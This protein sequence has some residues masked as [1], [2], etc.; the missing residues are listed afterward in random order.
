MATLVATSVMVCTPAL[1]SSM[2]VIGLSWSDLEASLHEN[3]HYILISLVDLSFYHMIKKCF[4]FLL[5]KLTTLFQ[6][7][8]WDSSDNGDDTNMIQKKTNVKIVQ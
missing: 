7:S 1:T 8:P 5:T 4:L 6:L 2:I 3:G